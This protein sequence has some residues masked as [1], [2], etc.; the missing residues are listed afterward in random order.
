MSSIR[1]NINRIANT[2][3]EP[4][5]N[6]LSANDF[7]ADEAKKSLSEECRSLPGT[8]FFGVS[9]ECLREHEAA[10][11]ADPDAYI[12]AHLGKP[13][14]PVRQYH[15][16]RAQAF[17]AVAR[18]YQDSPEE[19]TRKSAYRRELAAVEGHFDRVLEAYG[20]Y[21]FSPPYKASPALRQALLEELSR[22]PSYKGPRLF[23]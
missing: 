3:P 12:D 20:R 5:G 13:G 18:R 6:T 22:Y 7:L 15:D 2:Y 23:D 11:A 21:I 14:E 16:M 17:A 4:G 9:L 1:E 8:G 19:D 10:Y